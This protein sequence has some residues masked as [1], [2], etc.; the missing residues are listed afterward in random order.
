MTSR[1]NNWFS[2]IICIIFVLLF[3]Q[4][5]IKLFPNLL[6]LTYVKHTIYPI[7]S[8]R[9]PRNFN[10]FT[11]YSILIY[12]LYYRTINYFRIIPLLYPNYIEIENLDLVELFGNY[13]LVTIYALLALLYSIC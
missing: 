1:H 10:Y 11:K 5:I 8:I 12:Y 3:S 2:S 7:L 9:F 4:H 6:N 13:E